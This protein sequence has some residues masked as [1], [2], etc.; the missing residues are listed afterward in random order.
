MNDYIHPQIIHFAD[1]YCD[2]NWRPNTEL[3]NFYSITFVLDGCVY[4]KID[5][6]ERTAKKGDIV[7]IKP[8]STRTAKTNGFHCVALDFVL[9]DKDVQID[10]QNFTEYG[11]F[12][13][14]KIYFNELKREWLQKNEGYKLKCQA[15][16]M[17]ILHKLLYD[18]R[19][20]DKNPK[21]EKIKDYIIQN[22]AK[23]L[24]VAML[25][26]HVNLS[27]VYC[28]ALFKRHEKMTIGAFINRVRINASLE[29]LFLESNLTITQIAEDVGFT[30][31]YYFSNMFKQLV[32]VS[33]S[34]YRKTGH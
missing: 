5:G 4:Y 3:L 32:G 23:D 12:T 7:F 33:P 31:V 21:V 6:K 13:E 16:I 10:Y 1:K 15:L 25:A 8:G 24:N 9:A 29:L 19:G 18:V 22:Y 34:N 11:K 30:D 27:P 17:L 28:G 26:E 20:E 2:P 14:F